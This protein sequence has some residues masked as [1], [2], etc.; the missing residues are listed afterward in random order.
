[1][2]V[3]MNRCYPYSKGTNQ[4]H[5]QKI[6]PWVCRLPIRYMSKIFS[7][8]TESRE[9]FPGT[10]WESFK[11]WEVAQVGSKPSL[12]IYLLL[13]FSVNQNLNIKLG[14]RNKATKKQRESICVVYCFIVQ[15]HNDWG[16]PLFGNSSSDGNVGCIIKRI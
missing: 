10:F 7:R 8:V 14:K 2:V 4:K 12:F 1:M 5:D 6:L 13:F 3:I 11:V 15:K 9:E 16:Q